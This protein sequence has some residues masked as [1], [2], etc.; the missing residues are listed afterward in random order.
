MID[1]EVR[2]ELWCVVR[3]CLWRE[4]ERERERGGG[5]KQQLENFIFTRIDK[6]CSLVLVKNLSN[7]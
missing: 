6:E 3:P 1:R 7:N 4:R 5:K 2:T